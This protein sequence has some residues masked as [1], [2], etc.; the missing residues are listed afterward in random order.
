MD[1]CSKYSACPSPSNEIYH[2]REND[3]RITSK[4]FLS[5]RG[6]L[7]DGMLGREK[8]RR[9]YPEIMQGSQLGMWPPTSL[10][11]FNPEL[12]LSK[13]NTETKCGAVTERKAIQRLPHL[14]IHPIY[15]HQIQTL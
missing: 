10:Q 2:Q 1:K 6:M 14:G 11:F 15:R 12:F 7:L 8:L 9:P 13:G 5:G 3:G 4:K